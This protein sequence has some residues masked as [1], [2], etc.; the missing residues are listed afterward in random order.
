MNV[1]FTSD[2]HYSHTNLCEKFIRDD[3]T[4][5]R[6]FIPDGETVA[7]GFTSVLEMDE[8]M[9]E[10]HNRTVGQFDKIYFL[11]DVCF[12]LTRYHSIMPRL[13]GKKRLILGN[14]DKFDWAEYGRHFEKVMESWQPVR[15]ILFTHRPIYL[16][17][18]DHH[19]KVKANV[20]G[21]IHN[22]VIP[23]PVYL[24]IC[25][26]QTNYTPIHWDEIVTRLKRQGAKL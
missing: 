1:W 8:V 12:N 24:N 10:R 26:E 11:G 4:P 6:T 21:H 22:H 15:N 14:H 25:V 3:G 16:G 2:Q 23:S 9:I 20:H 17:A 5:A 19:E 13:N 18:E 7:R